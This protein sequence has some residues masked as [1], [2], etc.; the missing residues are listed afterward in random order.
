MGVSRADAAELLWRYGEDEL[1]VRMLDSTTQEFAEFLHRAPFATLERD[2]ATTLNRQ[3]ALCAVEVFSGAPRLP[4]RRRARPQSDVEG[5]WSDIGRDRA[6][7]PSASDD[8]HEVHGPPKPRIVRTGPY[9]R[10]R[11]HDMYDPSPQQLL[12]ILRDLDDRHPYFLIGRSRLDERTY[13]QAHR[14]GRGRVLVEHRAG[15]EETHQHL[16]TRSTREAADI[17]WAWLENTSDWAHDYPWHD[18]MADLRRLTSAQPP[19]AGF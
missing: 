2:H 15:A 5:F 13:A 16:T 8:W 19:S 7:Q 14:L 12:W 9:I 3:I 18:G 4:K 17:L 10:V 1:A 6:S 11:G